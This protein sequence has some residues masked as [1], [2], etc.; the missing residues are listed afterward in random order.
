MK[1]TTI[2]GLTVKN[3]VCVIYRPF[4]GRAKVRK[5]QIDKDGQVT[6][7]GGRHTVASE[8]LFTWKGKDPWTIIHQGTI[9]AL[10]PGPMGGVVNP[11][12]LNEAISNH[13]AGDVLQ[14][15]EDFDKKDKQST[16]VMVVL[17]M[18]FLATLIMGIWQLA[19]LN[20]LNH[21]VEFMQQQV[22][23]SQHPASQAQQIL[24]QQAASTATTGAPHA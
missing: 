1:A 13:Y 2:D 21:V 9:P 6:I 16:I 24:Q 3:S 23:A 7:N 12:F 20:S 11:Q 14:A 18:L 4:A 22:A 15:F 17:G 8:A 19:Q 10:A 5:C